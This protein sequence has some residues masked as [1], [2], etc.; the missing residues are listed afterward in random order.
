MNYEM[1][2]F[3]FRYRYPVT[4]PKPTLN[5]QSQEVRRLKRWGSLV[6]AGPFRQQ[7][8]EFFSYT[9]ASRSHHR[10]QQ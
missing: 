9:L 10:Y 1:I 2:D 4:K 7:Q 6:I 3:Q 5:L 8:H